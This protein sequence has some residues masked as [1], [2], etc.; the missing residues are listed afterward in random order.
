MLQC[1]NNTQQKSIFVNEAGLNDEKP[2]QTSFATHMHLIVSDKNNVN[3]KRKI[4]ERT[5]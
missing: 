4:G 3:F 5:Q 2:D 1:K